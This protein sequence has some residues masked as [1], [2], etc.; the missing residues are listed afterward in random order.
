M[1]IPRGTADIDLLVHREDMLKV[2]VIM[3]SLG[4]EHRNR[5]ENVSQY[6]SPLNIFGEVDFI[7]AFRTHSMSMLKRVEERQVFDRLM[8][9]KVV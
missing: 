2:D 4:Y 7:H 9:I 3:R 8:S 5:T 6:I 1:G